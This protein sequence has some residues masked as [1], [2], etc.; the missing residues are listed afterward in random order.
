DAVLGMHEMVADREVAERLDGGGVGP[1]GLRA[2]ALARAEDLLLGHH[3]EALDREREALRERGD[4]DLDRARPRPAP[5][6]PRR[7]LDARGDAVLGE[8]RAQALGV[9][10]RGGGEHRAPALRAPDAELAGERRQR[11]L[12]AARAG[13]L[14]T[15]VVVRGRAE[16]VALARRVGEVE[17]VEVHRAA[18]VDRG[19]ELVGAEGELRG[20]R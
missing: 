18:R 4:A 8:E 6:R 1:A 16:R 5:D 7:A 13:E 17:A 2:L 12:A 14:A 15:Q 19:R 3:G 20:R 9:R 10:E 11:S